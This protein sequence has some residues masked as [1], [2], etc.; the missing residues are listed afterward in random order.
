[1]LLEVQLAQ[2]GYPLRLADD[3]RVIREKRAH[4]LLGLH[5]TF[6]A[7]EAEPL[8]IVEV[9]SGA[10]RQQ[11]V[12]CFGILAPQ[13][14]RVVRGHHR[15]AEFARKLEHALGDDF[16]I[17]DCVVL[18]L[19][20]VA[21]GT[22]VRRVPLRRPFGFLVVSPAQPE[23]HLARETCGE[24]NHALAVLGEYFPVYPRP[25]VESF[26]EADRRQFDDILVAGAVLGE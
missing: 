1:M 12:V 25:T 20:P 16:L 22:V 5:I 6:L 26:D 17:I 13:I 8:R 9:L 11:D 2:V 4:L 19:E 18:H 23:R 3:L 14:V 21:V 15:K 24:T 7:L 10:D